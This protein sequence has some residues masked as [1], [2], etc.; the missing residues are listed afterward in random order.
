MKLLRNR[1]VVVALSLAAVGVVFYQAFSGRP[2]QPEPASQP[3]PAAAPPVPEKKP[4]PRAQA[5]PPQG[6]GFGEAAIDLFYAPAHMSEWLDSPRR[7]P[8]LLERPFSDKGSGPSPLSPLAHWKLKAIWRQTGGR[9]AA[10]NDRVYEEGESIE[11]YKIEKIEGDAV[12]FD[13]PR[14]K[15]RLGFEKAETGARPNPQGT[16]TGNPP[17]APTNKN[18]PGVRS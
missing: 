10:I 12:W 4:S 1:W 11:G 2:R 6:N 7:D 15:E 3:P 17:S 16:G 13:G 8:F 14:G 9:V 18:P 5:P